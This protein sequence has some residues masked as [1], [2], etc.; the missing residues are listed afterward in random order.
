VKDLKDAGANPD[1]LTGEAGAHPVAAGIGAAAAGAA[2]L[3]VS[4]VVAG[5]IGVMVATAGGALAGGYIGK[6]VGEILDPTAEEAFWREEHP[7]QTYAEKETGF[8]DYLAA[9]RTGFEGYRHFGREGRTFD[10]AEPELQKLYSQT[11]AR[12]PWLKAR[13]AARAAWNR[14]QAAHATKDDSAHTGVG[15]AVLGE[16]TSSGALS[17]AQMPR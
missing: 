7:K 14:V 12:L 1:P 4:A 17:N 8:D 13:F 6:A 11:A 10:D 3:A 2:G 16:N 5:P 15:D 9:Y